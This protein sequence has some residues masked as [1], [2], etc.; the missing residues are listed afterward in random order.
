MFLLE[1]NIPINGI[2]SMIYRKTSTHNGPRSTIMLVALLKWSWS[3][4]YPLG[5]C[6]DN[7]SVCFQWDLVCANNYYMEMSQSLLY[8]GALVGDLL[9]SPLIGRKLVAFT[10]AKQKKYCHDVVVTHR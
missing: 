5:V 9:C 6:S 2:D 4:P 8:V 1:S 7:C 3:G 10:L